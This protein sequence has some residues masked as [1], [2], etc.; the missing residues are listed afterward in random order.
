VTSTYPPIGAPNGTF[1][2]R[3]NLA[4]LT[5]EIAAATLRV[6]T[7]NTT[8][9]RYVRVFATL[10]DAWSESATSG[11]NATY[12]I[13]PNPLPAG[14]GFLLPTSGG[15]YLD[16]SF[17]ELTDYVRA[18]HW[19]DGV[20]SLA[21]RMV[22][23]TATFQTDEGANRPQ[24]VVNTV[25]PIPVADIV[26]VSPDPRGSSVN[27]ISVAFSEPVAGL[28]L[29]DLAL[30]RDGSVIA[31]SGATLAS[32][33]GGITWA[34]GNLASL[35]GRVGSYQITLDSAGS[36]IADANGFALIAGAGDAWQ[37]NT[38]GGTIG[39]N[40]I[41]LVRNGTVT[42]YFLDDAFQ[43]SFN[44]SL[45]TSLVI[46]PG[47]GDDTVS[48]DFANGAPVPAS[49]IIDG[50]PASDTLR[51]TGSTGA[52]AADFDTASIALGGTA[53]S[54]AG[55]DEVTFDGRG[56][57]DSLTVNG[58]AIALAAT[59]RFN[60]LSIDTSDAR[61]DARDHDILLDASPLGTFDGTTY[62][63]VLG[64]I[65]AGYNFSEW[66][67]NGL[68]TTMPAAQQGL[69][70]LAPASAAELYGLGPGD[71]ALY[72]G[73]TVD[74]TTVIVKYT[75]AGDVNFDGLVDAADYGVIDNWVQFP[76][77]DGYA[78]GDFNFD[79][80]IDAADYG[81]ID[82]TIQLQGTPL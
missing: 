75:Y 79:G 15:G 36:G 47:A 81:I 35:T 64:L 31:L 22:S 28:D 67:G 25:A 80:I 27:S 20:V 57:G 69:T 65:A 30:T 40:D 26:D 76:G 56:G 3:F 5:G 74:A 6:F 49:T 68:V 42:D 63:G 82:N 39:P 54:H 12:P 8:A 48:I 29:N 66:T 41:R 23:G 71:T 77:T 43:Y 61:L 14:G 13:H 50:G 17:R 38:I 34:L 70:T 73:H 9:S 62:S 37:M 33:D 46:A 2:L 16:I 53:I 59:Q 60:T 72:D 51:L 55:I 7:T 78:N 44:P 11:I 18:Q 10:D 19:K 4:A 1:F 45:L 58:G 21:L 24:L 32:S 52:D